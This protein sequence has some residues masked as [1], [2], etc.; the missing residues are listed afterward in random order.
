MDGIASTGV[1]VVIGL[2]I[3]VMAVAVASKYIRI[4]YTI[5]LVLVG[6][7]V[8]LTPFRLPIN[9]TPDLILFIFLPALLFEASYN[10]S[11]AELRE[12][13]RPITFLAVPGVLL[14]AVI[15]AA[16]MYFAAGVNWGTAF[17]F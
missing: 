14:T 15:L 12:N 10:I 13:L 17:L 9:L 11:F 8:S 3:G 16:V 4:P 7:A 2:L 6:L 1:S 5:A